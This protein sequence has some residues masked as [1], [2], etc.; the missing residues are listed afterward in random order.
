MIHSQRYFRLDTPERAS[1]T[2]ELEF[3]SDRPI[4]SSLQLAGKAV[5]Q[6]CS[7]YNMPATLHQLVN[8]LRI[9]LYGLV[10]EEV[11]WRQLSLQLVHN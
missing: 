6:H 8:N 1:D 11:I 10:R 5:Q 4:D 3:A 9:T 2:Y 7:V